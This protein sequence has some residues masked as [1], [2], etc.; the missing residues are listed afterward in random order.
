MQ[1]VG[2]M[3]F[4]KINDNQISGG[5]CG[6]AMSMDNHLIGINEIPIRNNILII[7]LNL[8]LIVESI[9]K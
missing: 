1:I 8:N 6:M 2:K 4:K 7:K 5:F 3:K 9:E